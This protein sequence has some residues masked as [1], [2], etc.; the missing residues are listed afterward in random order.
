MPAGTLPA[1]HG[2]N[3]GF[4]VQLEQ[5]VRFVHGGHGL[6][7]GE[8]DHGRIG[9]IRD[10]QFFD[11]FFV[12]GGVF[13]SRQFFAEAVKSEPVVNALRQNAAERLFP[14]E[15]QKIAD[16]GAVCRDRRRHAGGSAAD[17]DKVFFHLFSSFPRGLYLVR[18][19]FRRELPPDFVTSSYGIPS[20]RARI[21]AIYG[22]QK[23]P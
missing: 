10:F 14:F 17:D 15:N 7:G 4:R 8:R 6:V 2:Q 13:G 20:S 11:F 3:D 16:T 5:A 12:A 23:P 22:V 1:A 19:T 21:P 18:P 9:G